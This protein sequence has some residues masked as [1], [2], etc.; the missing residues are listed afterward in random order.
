M[1]YYTI[2]WMSY[3]TQD[4]MKLNRKQIIGSVIAAGSGED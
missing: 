3:A 1:P 4:V 2:A